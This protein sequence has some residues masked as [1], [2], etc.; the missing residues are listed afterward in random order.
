MSYADQKKRGN[1]ATLAAAIALNGSIIM[2]VALSPI[3]VD[4]IRDEGLKITNIRVDP[5]PPPEKP[6]EKTQTTPRMPPSSPAPAP[7]DFTTSTDLPIPITGGVP[8]LDGGA[9]A[10][11][12]TGGVVLPI[13]DPPK[14]IFRKAER[15]PRYARNF[16][17]DYPVGLLQKEIEGSAKIK[18]LIG[19]DGRVRQA[20]L[21]S[22]SHPDFG[23]AAEK[24]A[25]R[26]WR[27]KPATR[28]GVAVE[29]WQTLTVTFTIDN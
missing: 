13:A 26:E 2:A 4:H 19:T 9:T 25:L 6:I 29:E 3:V 5:A 28:D 14:P 22:A 1:P 23:K 27:F 11:D 15:D 12:G 18:V 24:Q 16:Q 7:V 10:G 8:T 21:V 20:I 17:P